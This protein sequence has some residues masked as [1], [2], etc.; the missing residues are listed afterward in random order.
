MIGVQ[1]LRD[2]FEFCG[3]CVPVPKLNRPPQP[4]SHLTGTNVL[5]GTLLRFLLSVKSFRNPRVRF[6][7]LLP[8]LFRCQ[9]HFLSSSSK[10]APLTASPFDDGRTTDNSADVS[11][12]VPSPSRHNACQTG[13]ARTLSASASRRAFAC[14]CRRFIC[15]FP[16]SEYRA[17][18]ARIAFA[19]FRR[20][21][22]Q[23]HHVTPRKR[24]SDEASDIFRNSSERHPA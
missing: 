15:V 3:R 20:S 18:F 21:G 11:T 7:N 13:D 4:P 2:R 22:R 24:L 16:I 17:K 9:D 12:P 5:R 1:G 19:E 14:R 6:P 8:L 23:S 10:P